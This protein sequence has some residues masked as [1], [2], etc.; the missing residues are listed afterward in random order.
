MSN[1]EIAKNMIDK[2]P[3]DKIIYIINILENIGEMYGLNIYPEYSPNRE[4][5]AAAEEVDQM[6]K[7]GTGEHYCGSTSDF[8]ANMLGE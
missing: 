1:Q 2:L 7:N 6:I 4:T 8:F 5:I 3:E